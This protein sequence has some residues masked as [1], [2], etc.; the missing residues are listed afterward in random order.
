MAGRG[1]TN[2]MFAEL[3]PRRPSLTLRRESALIDRV[4]T[5]APGARLRL[6]GNWRRGSRD[7]FLSSVEPLPAVDPTPGG[8]GPQMQEDQGVS[9]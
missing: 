4:A 8:N 3:W 7:F 5:A 6:L 9:P 2:A 1:S